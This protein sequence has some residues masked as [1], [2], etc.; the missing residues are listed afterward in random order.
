METASRWRLKPQHR[1]TEE[2]YEAI[3]T[4]ATKKPRDWMLLFIPG[5]TA[6]R[7][8]EVLHLRVRDFDRATGIRI[9]RRKKHELV[10]DVLQVAPD[11]FDYVERW[12]AEAVLG[13][14]DWLFPGRCGPCSRFVTDVT[15]DPATRQ[16]IARKRRVEQVCRE[17]GHLTTRRALAVW[18]RYLKR[19]GLKVRG[20][21]IHTLRHYDLTR[22]QRANKDLRATQLRAGHSSPIT[23]AIYAD[24][25]DMEEKAERAGISAAGSPWKTPSD[26]GSAGVKRVSKRPIRK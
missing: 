25:V 2:Q 7:I 3:L 19:L 11:L 14:D 6:L 21:G 4:A 22:F 13:P 16:V 23:T 10:E 1:I 15:R 12:V 9:V 26:P 8:S 20:R 18:D 5:N 17:G 24:I